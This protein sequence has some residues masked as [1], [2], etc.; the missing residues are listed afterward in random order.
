MFSKKNISKYLF[1]LLNSWPLSCWSWPVAKLEMYL[2][3]ILLLSHLS[4]NELS[5]LNTSTYHNHIVHCSFKFLQND[6]LAKSRWGQSKFDNFIN[7]NTAMCTKN[8]HGI[9]LLPMVRLFRALILL[10]CWGWWVRTRLAGSGAVGSGVSV[11]LN[12]MCCLGTG[13]TASLLKRVPFPHR[14][15][16]LP[17]NHCRDYLQWASGLLHRVYTLPASWS[18]PG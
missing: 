5:P 13:G 8:L 1:L 14:H 15:H 7:V 16:L 12:R 18:P 11:F 17:I 10:R 9:H 3:E 4:K 2:P 6:V